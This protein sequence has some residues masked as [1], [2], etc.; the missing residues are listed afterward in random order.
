MQKSKLYILV[1]H[2]FFLL[3]F[4]LLLSGFLMFVEHSH[5]TFSGVMNYY[6]PKTVFGLLETITPHLFGMGIVLFILSHFYTVIQGFSHSKM[7]RVSF[8][9]FIAMILS[10]FSTLFISSDAIFFTAIKLISTLLFMILSIIL[11]IDLVRKL[12]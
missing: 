5:L 10:N 8:L 6:S 1:I 12:R 2:Y 9:L 4:M 11:M 3:L 7:Y